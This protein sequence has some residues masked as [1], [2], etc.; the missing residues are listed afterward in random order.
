MPLLLPPGWWRLKRDDRWG[1][2]FPSLGRGCGLCAAG[3]EGVGRGGR[4]T[5]ALSP[6]F[7]VHCR[8]LNQQVGRTWKKLT[9]VAASGIRRSSI[10]SSGTFGHPLSEKTTRLCVS[11]CKK[12]SKRIYN[13]PLTS[14]LSS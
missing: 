5:A 6:H 2:A 3:D 14:S 9:S 10:N 8:G 12:K 4:G 1:V 13:I 7:S 11:K